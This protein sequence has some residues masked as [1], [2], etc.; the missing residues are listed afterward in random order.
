[1]KKTFLYSLVLAS[2][3]LTGCTSP[4]EKE[5]KSASSESS[6]EAVATEE[7]ITYLDQ[8]YAVKIPTTNII[9]ASV[10]T[11]EDAAALNIQPLGA[12]TVGGEIP[13]YIA[14]SL[15]KDVA[16]VGDKFGPNVELV[17][18]LTPDVILGS[19]K[20]DD[21]VTKNLEKI[22]PTINVSHV[23]EN[24][25]DNLKL[26]GTLSGKE[27][28]ADKLISDYETS[29]KETKEA[30][31]N[32]GDLKVV[33]LRV[34]GG[35]LCLYGE[36]VY[37]NPMLYTDLGFKKPAEIDKVKGQETISVEQFS[38]IN[39]DI[40]FVQFAKEENNGHENFIDNLKNDPIWQSMAAAK[41]DKVY[42]D[43]VDGGYQGG[44]YLSK[45]VMLDALN[46]DVLK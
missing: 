10:E 23:S 18:T 40:V 7:K 42:Y 3:L 1:M 22:A 46:K 30:Q 11:M 9:T 28:E 17:T 21:D 25:K 34:R 15:G 19:T 31:P 43:I 35:E 27:E 41:N 32:I 39:P 12:V 2:L 20:F 45:K 14:P 29:L 5:V 4:K 26:L 16:N 33:I 13:S 8:E 38:K 37:Y 24:W 44:T 36:N 6:V